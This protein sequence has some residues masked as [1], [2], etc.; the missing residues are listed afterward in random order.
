MSYEAELKC[1]WRVSNIQIKRA[2]RCAMATATLL[3]G[4]VTRSFVAH[5]DNGSVFLAA[6]LTNDLAPCTHCLRK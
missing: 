1:S 5:N 4:L 2:R 3:N 6:R